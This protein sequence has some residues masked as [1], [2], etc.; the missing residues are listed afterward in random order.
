MVFPAMSPQVHIADPQVWGDCVGAELYRR[1]SS[2][3]DH[4]DEPGCTAIP[5]C[6]WLPQYDAEVLPNPLNFSKP[7]HLKTTTS[8]VENV[9][10]G[11]SALT[12]G[13]LEAQKQCD[14]AVDKAICSQKQFTV[15]TTAMAAAL[16]YKASEESSSPE[17][18]QFAAAGFDDDG[19][20][21]EPW[22]K[23]SALKSPSTAGAPG[24]AVDASPFDARQPRK[25]G[26]IPLPRPAAVGPAPAVISGGAATAVASAASTAPAVRGV[27][28]SQTGALGGELCTTPPTCVAAEVSLLKLKVNK[29]ALN[30]LRT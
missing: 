26:K 22:M 8:P 28:P 3:C 30:S 15:P 17:D 2:V 25:V 9:F 10:L 21:A 14:E 11:P 24:P 1:Y 18:T 4:Y 20:G 6:N 19:P 5:K 23:G 12:K 16:A 7:C 27:T 29:A 13:A